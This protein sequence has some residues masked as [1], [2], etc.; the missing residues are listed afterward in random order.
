MTQTHFIL[1]EDPFELLFKDLFDTKSIFNSFVDCKP[2]HPTDIYED[3][4]GLHIEIA[5]IGLSDENVDIT[6]EG[7]LLKV[8]YGKLDSESDIDRKYIY[9]GITRKSFNMGWKIGSQFDINKL[10]AVIDKGLLEIVIPYNE[11]SAPKKVNIQTK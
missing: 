1:P 10:K 7:S 2:T 6:T 5:T 11:A 8:R 9:R 4:D 3:K